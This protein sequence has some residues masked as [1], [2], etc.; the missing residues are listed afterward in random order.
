METLIICKTKKKTPYNKN[1][2]NVFIFKTT[3]NT[4]LTKPRP[5]LDKTVHVR[6]VFKGVVKMTQYITVINIIKNKIIS[7][8]PFF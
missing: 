1:H 3:H 4:T 6:H 7:C 8:N 2:K 5:N